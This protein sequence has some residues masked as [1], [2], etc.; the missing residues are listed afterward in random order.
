H[1]LTMLAGRVYLRV[2]TGQAAA[3]PI[4]HLYRWSRLRQA[5]DFVVGLPLSSIATREGEFFCISLEGVETVGV[6]EGS[7]RVTA[8]RSPEPQTLNAGQAV[9]IKDG[10]FGN[11]RPMSEAEREAGVVDRERAALKIEPLDV[12][13]TSLSKGAAFQSWTREGGGSASNWKEWTAIHSSINFKSPQ[14][15][16]TEKGTVMIQAR[17]PVHKPVH[18]YQIEVREGE[19]AADPNGL[20]VRPQVARPRLKAL[21]FKMRVI[22]VDRIV[23]HVKENTTTPEHAIFL[24]SEAGEWQDYHVPLIDAPLAAQKPDLQAYW[25]FDFVPGGNFSQVK[26]RDPLE[27]HLIEMKDFQAVLLK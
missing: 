18:G 13:V 7:V 24:N 19:P 2:K 27:T 17:S 11:V 16:L 4:R 21:K 25:R 22:N 3:P 20:L 14:A 6:H 10:V 1:S 8:A 26:G 12:S 15:K 23:H 5:L 9:E